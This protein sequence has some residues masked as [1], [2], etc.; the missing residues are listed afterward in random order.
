M[1]RLV[2]RPLAGWSDPVTDP[3]RSHSFSS[4]WTDTVHA[5]LYEVERLGG[6]RVVLQVQAD[7]RAM[8]RD[9]GIRA[10]ARVR[11]DGVVVSF[12]SRYGPLRYACDT[13]TAAWSWQLPGWQ[14]NVRAIA[15][16]LEALRKV[17]RYGIGQRGEQYTGWAA[18]TAGAPTKI[19]S[20]MDAATIIAKASDDPHLGGFEVLQQW[21]EYGPRYYRAAARA[22]H[23]DHGGDAETFRLVQQARDYLNNNTPQEDQ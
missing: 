18:L 15:L 20:S 7:D 3:R 6:D 10:D 12:D 4:G 22:S 9:G 14:A 21:A 11:D 1:A 5:L 17:A 23:P 19:T 16:G 13:F 2:Y 8:R